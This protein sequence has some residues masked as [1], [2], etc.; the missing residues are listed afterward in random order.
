MTSATTRDCAA[1]GHAQEE[2][3]AVGCSRP[4]EWDSLGFVKRRCECLGV[5]VQSPQGEGTQGQ[6]TSGKRMGER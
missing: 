2:H 1:C 4:V 6:G 5:E 3:G